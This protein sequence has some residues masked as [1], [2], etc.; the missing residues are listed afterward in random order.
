MRVSLLASSIVCCWLVHP[1]AR[2]EA[3]DDDDDDRATEI[4][5]D[6][7]L[8]K[9]LSD[10]AKAKLDRVADRLD[11]TQ[12]AFVAPDLQIPDLNIDV[13]IDIDIDVDVDVDFSDGGDD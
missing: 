11:H 1:P 4:D 5:A 3:C 10:D 13:D 7:D 8:S 9:T 2:A 6:T 12:L